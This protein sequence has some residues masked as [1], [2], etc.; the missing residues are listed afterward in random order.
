MTTDTAAPVFDLS[1]LTS[2]DGFTIIG[3]VSADAL[4]SGISS[5]GDVNGDGIDDMIVGAY[6]AS[7]SSKG[8]AGSS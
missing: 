6:K 1:T 3:A 7:P 5:A 4:G 8:T 2:K